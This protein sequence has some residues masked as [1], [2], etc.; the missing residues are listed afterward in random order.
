MSPGRGG[1]SVAGQRVRALARLFDVD[2]RLRVAEEAAVAA[3]TRCEDLAQ[4]RQSR[5]GGCVC[6]DVQSRG[7]RDTLELMLL[8]ACLEQSL[9]PALLVSP[10]PEGTDVESLRAERALDRRYIEL[11]VV[12]QHHDRGLVIR[13]RLVDRLL[14]PGDEQLVRTGD[15]L[16]RRELAASIR[17]DRPPAQLLRGG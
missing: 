10:R 5:F 14:R 15:P 11:V 13:L 1:T 7:T 16:L 4:D 6:A 9:A 3:R 12:G 17:D 8:D 2:S